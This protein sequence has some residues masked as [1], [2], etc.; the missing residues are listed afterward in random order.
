MTSG[1]IHTLRLA[2]FA[3]IQRTKTEVYSTIGRLFFVV[4]YFARRAATMTACQGQF[5]V[6]LLLY[7][8]DVITGSRMIASVL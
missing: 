5:C 4:E 2:D 6:V 3:L 7:F 1:S 8:D